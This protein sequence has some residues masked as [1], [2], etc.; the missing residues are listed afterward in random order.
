MGLNNSL[1]R[2]K[3]PAMPTNKSPFTF[4]LDETLLLKIKHVAKNE[5]RS[6]SNLLEHLCKICVM[7]YEKKNGEIVVNDEE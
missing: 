2:K 5:T 6:T 7:D 1:Y 3:V 4:H